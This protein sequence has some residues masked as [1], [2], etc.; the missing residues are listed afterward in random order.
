MG[1]F[2]NKQEDKDRQELTNS[3]TYVYDNGDE[4]SVVCTLEKQKEIYK[5]YT[6]NNWDT[7][8]S[9]QSA[10]GK[11]LLISLK[12]IRSIEFYGEDVKTLTDK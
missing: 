11:Q 2:P 8:T 4:V 9:S 5:A 10:E 7:I 6:S 12:K 1:I 3:I